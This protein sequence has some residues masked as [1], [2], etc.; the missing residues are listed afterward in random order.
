MTKKE[1]V[2]LFVQRELQ[3]V[4]QEWARIVAEH[5]GEYPAFGM[6]GTVFL[7]GDWLSEKCGRIGHE[8]YYS[9]EDTPEEVL[10]EYIMQHIEG[11]LSDDDTDALYNSYDAI[12][13]RW[14][15]LIESFYED[16]CDEEMAGAWRVVGNI[17]A[18]EVADQYV[19]SINAAGFDFYD[20]S[21]GVWPRLYDA[22]GLQWHD[23][24][25]K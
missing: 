9:P 10:Q 12:A 5:D 8:V 15:H 24:D 2:E 17:Y 19:L 20:E 14:P 22:L 11:D 18:H 7:I 23:N 25:T 3:C 6:W 21:Y 1:A 4:P 13:E 16:Y